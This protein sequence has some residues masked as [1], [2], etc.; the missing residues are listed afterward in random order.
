MYKVQYKQNSV[1][2]TWTT[3][4]IYGTE[5]EAIANAMRK[6]MAGAAITRVIDRNQAIIFTQ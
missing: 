1:L 2:E 4:G 5:Q 3:M 6:R